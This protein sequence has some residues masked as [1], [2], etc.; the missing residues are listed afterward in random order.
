[1][2]CETTVVW[3]NIGLARGR[4]VGLGRSV[5]LPAETQV[6]DASGRL[7]TIGGGHAR[8]LQPCVAMTQKDRDWLSDRASLGA[9]PAMV[10]SDLVFLP[11]GTAGFLRRI[12]CALREQRQ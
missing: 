2:S 10:A 6:L 1:M 7:R 8:L 11:L 5:P 12:G 3:P 4:L 9:H